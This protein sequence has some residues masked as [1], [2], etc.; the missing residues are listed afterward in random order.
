VAN[1]G[2]GNDKI[3]LVRE[4]STVEFAKGDGKDSVFAA[5]DFVLAISGY[6]KDDVSVTTENGNLVISFAGSDDAITVNLPDE[7][8]I[9]LSFNDG[10]EM[11][12]NGADES[13]SPKFGVKWTSP[14]WRNAL[15]YLE[16]KYDGQ[17]SM[18]TLPGENALRQSRHRG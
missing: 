12:I 14:E 5:D 10:S 4:G 3:T 2:T 18:Y 1:G 9:Q 15:P 6:G 8:E 7:R 17:D 16:G 13:S 11:T